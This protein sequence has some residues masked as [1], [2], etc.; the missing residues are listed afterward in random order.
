M[1]NLLEILIEESKSY[2]SIETIENI[3]QTQQGV[4]NIPVQPLYQC[5]KKMAKDEVALYLE[6]MSAKQRFA[7]LDIDLWSKDDLDI[8]HFSFWFE[9]YSKSSN[10]DIRKEFIL[11]EQFVLFLKGRLSIHTFDLEEPEYPD[12]DYY[13]LTDDNQLL[14]EYDEEFMFVSEL[15]FYIGELYDH[16]GVEGAYAYLFKITVDSF[17]TFMEDSY[18]DK[19]SR[20]KDLGIVDYY[21][22]LET[23]SPMT[24][25]GHIDNYVK[26]KK[27]DKESMK[28]YETNLSLPNSALTAYRNPIPNINEE[29]SK[30]TDPTRTPFVQFSFIKMVNSTLVLDDC[31]KEG[32]VAMSKVGMEAVVLI[33]LG[34]DYLLSVIEKKNI[35]FGEEGIFKIFDFIDLYRFGLT[36]IRK[37][38]KKLRLAYGTN[39]DLIEKFSGQLFEN[40]YENSFAH[41]VT[42]GKVSEKSKPIE[43]LEMHSVWIEQIEL[44]ISCNAFIIKFEKTF[45][46][47]KDNGSI[48]DS[49][50]LNYKVDDIDFEAILITTF[51][52]YSLGFFDQ[53]QNSKKLGIMI[54]DFKNFMKMIS[55]E[56]MVFNPYSDSLDVYL[57]KFVSEFGFNKL[58][59]FKDYFLEVLAN[60][61]EGYEFASISHDDFKHVGGVILL[62][63]S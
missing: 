6:H 49:F 39:N 3:L 63:V 14:L 52:N 31:F 10:I 58:K 53:D 43:S 9:I 27:I 11:S 19:K 15:K 24:S 23:L 13:F 42:F 22:A 5:L 32:S 8:E 28:D 46:E 41:P 29:L 12:H 2:S 54:K 56:S 44:L 59:G 40:L 61:L 47:I 57:D 62:S 35:S 60:N 51:V 36:L 26:N 25:M 21:D 16:L 50:Y 17:L 30:L 1:H 38:Q 34:Y 33:K 7:M 37:G 55:S 4:G 48:Q 20:L 18:Q 45:L